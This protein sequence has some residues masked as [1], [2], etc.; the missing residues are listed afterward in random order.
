M[1]E[2]FSFVALGYNIIHRGI[3]MYEYINYIQRS[4]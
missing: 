4:K 3:S 2:S 1:V